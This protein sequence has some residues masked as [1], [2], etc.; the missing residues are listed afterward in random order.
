MTKENTVN[1]LRN[2]LL[3]LKCLDR[4]DPNLADMWNTSTYI[5]LQTNEQTIPTHIH[6]YKHSQL[7][8]NA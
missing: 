3:N 8:F 4:F 2:L 6:I 7:P 5:H 1:V